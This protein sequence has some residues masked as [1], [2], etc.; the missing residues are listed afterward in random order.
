[1]ELRREKI[2]FRLWDI[3]D[4]VGQLY[5]KLKQ[6][7]T[8]KLVISLYIIAFLM[9]FYT[10][11]R[12]S[13][14]LPFGGDFVLQQIPFYFNGYDDYYQWL[15][16]GTFPLWDDSGFLGSNNIGSNTFYY[17]L[18]PFF[19]PILLF[20]RYLVPQAQAFMMITKMVLA[21]I[22]MD[23][24]LKQFK[25]KP[26][27]R[28]LLSIAYAF[29]GWNMYYLWFNH[30]LEIAVLMPLLLYGIEKIIQERKPLPLCLILFATGM[31]NYFFLISFCFT[32]VIYAMF[33]YFQ[34]VKSMEKRDRF[35][36]IGYGVFAFAAGILLSGM[37]LIP[38]FEVVLSNSRVTNA[39][40]LPDLTN[41]LKNFFN[42]KSFDSLKDFFE[43]LVTWNPKYNDITEGKTVMYP[44]LTFFL[45]TS[46]CFSSLF[47]QNKWYEDSLSSLFSYTPMMLMLVPSLIQS[48]KEKK[49]SHILGFLGICFLLFTPFAYN[50]FSGFTSEMYGRWQIFVVA[51]F[52]VYVAINFD[53]RRKMSVHYLDLSIVV[54]LLI[55]LFLFQ[56]CKDFYATAAK[57]G[58]LSKLNLGAFNEQANYYFYFQ[59]IF[60]IIV[61]FYIRKGFKNRDLAKQLI[62][63]VALEAII[64]GNVVSIGSCTSYSNLYGGQSNINEETRMIANL[65]E[66]DSSYYR[67]FTTSAD[68]DGTNLGMM[69]GYR[70]VGSFHSI[71]NYNLWDFMTW[72]D[73]TYNGSWSGAIHEKRQNL[74]Q[75]LGIKYYLLKKD[76]T[77]IPY[78]FIRYKEEQN[79]VLY[80]NTNFIELGYA[81]DDYISVVS[82]DDFSYASALRKEEYYLKSAILYDKDA[83]EVAEEYS[84]LNQIRYN[85]AD[86]AITRT[87]GTSMIYPKVYDE[88]T[89]Q[90]I[91]GTPVNFTSS[92]TQNLLYNSY[93]ETSFGNSS[94]CSQAS[95][96]NGCFVSVRQR[97]GENLDI[98]LYGVD[99][100]GEDVLITHDTHMTHWYDKSGDRKYERGFYVDQPVKKV[101]IILKE[102][103]DNNRALIQPYYSYSYNDTYQDTI[104][105]LKQSPLLNIKNSQDH[106]SF[107]TEF[108]KNKIVVLQIPYD[109]GWSI[110]ATNASGQKENV[111]LYQGQGGF[112]TFIAKE[113]ATHYEMSY[114]TPGLGL[115]IKVAAVGT[116]IT[117]CL[118]L[119]YIYL[120]E[121]KKNLKKLLSE[122]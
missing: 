67:L 69:F 7:R 106:F 13:F 78:G 61:F 49:I 47:L 68:R 15:T 8:V 23:I 62:Y 60:E 54:V 53:K 120:Y 38:A 10:L 4:K 24:L 93:I 80:L 42:L 14:T 25:V 85:S 107:D 94:I 77:N 64:M 43:I 52:M 39:Q 26:D 111:K 2:Q 90:V 91:D 88:T 66:E 11:I 33:R 105:K 50:C 103:M 74:D 75:F 73:V 112:V 122:F 84:D 117:S 99:E 57:E 116:F 55:Q 1:M 72:S 86:S 46:N 29:C 121:E 119:S 79:H 95:S 104:D 22:T 32:G 96:R 97:M 118:Y 48:I 58:N 59:I 5:E 114:V 16:T 40:Y 19:L 56:Y 35:I 18:N 76:D 17:L 44:L 102:N 81:F 92:A 30:F 28:F 31:T 27:T 71:Y 110:Q 51:I 65:K 98:Y 101:K 12:N 63:V 36:V 109:S 21:G 70:G 115:G 34:T 89:G 100:N 83:K 113:G 20:P 6:S 87:S 3:I 108:D 82:N 9:F 37:V 41:A 45:P